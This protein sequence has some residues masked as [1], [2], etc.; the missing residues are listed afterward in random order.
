MSRLV[1]V[2]NRVAVPGESRAGGLA[3]G[4]LA[5]LRERGGL[6][7]GWN[8]KVARGESG[9]L[10]EQDDGDIR[11]VTMDLNKRDLDAYYNGFANRT[12]WP[13]LH[14]RLDLVDYDRAKRDGYRRVNAMFAD[15]LAPMLRED[16]TVWIHDYHLIPLASLLRERGIGCKI[17]FFLHVPMPSA[18]L[19]QA[20]PDHARLFST[21]YAY[22]LVG[23]Q[24]QR[25]VDRFLSYVRLFGGGR[26]LGDGE[27]EAPGGRRLRA[28]AFPIGIDTELIARQA[29]AAMSKQAVRNLRGSL[30][31]RQLA[32]G[33]DR[34]DYSKGLPERFRGFER[35]LER[36]PD[37]H[38]TLTYLQIAPVSR[39]EVSEY[40]DLRSQLEQIA[41]HINGGHAEPDWTPLRYVNQNFTHATLTGFYRS[42]AVGLVT[43]LRDGMNLVAKEYVAAQDPDDPGVLVLSLLAGAADELR[44]ALL[45][46]PH[47]LDG[48]ADAIATA[49]TLSRPKRIERW[50]A[51]MEHLRHNDINHWRQ[52]Y[53]EALDAA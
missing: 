13:L 10:H 1:V 22:D 35:Y 40:R 47:D 42:A 28:A 52:R 33:V 6:W 24:T 19:V 23:F 37:Q 20:M 11:F 48:V 4:L 2:S 25:D 14:F 21:L 27:L 29:K 15:K 17:G 43:P 18:D 41:G 50:Q 12:L 36:H 38:G 32:I 26:L 45:V 31:D 3:V 30:R 9:A 46:N 16:D 44:E 5:A 39:G 7:F 49:A 34:L 51:M 53:L 8:G